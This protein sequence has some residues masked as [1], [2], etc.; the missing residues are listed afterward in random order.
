MTMAAI[1]ARRP[2]RTARLSGARSLP[3]FLL[4]LLT[5]LSCST[6]TV[7]D[8]VRI[9]GQIFGTSYHIQAVSAREIDVPSLST[10][11]SHRLD[12]IDRRMSTYR[13]DSDVSRFNRAETGAW[14]PVDEETAAVVSLAQSVSRETAGCFDI[15]VGP[16]VRLW[17]FGAGA[18]KRFQPPNEQQIAETLTIVGFEKLDVQLAPPAL[19]KSVSGL[20]IDLSAIAKGHAVDAVS[21]LL[22]DHEISGYLVE[23]GGEV[24]AFGVNHDGSAWRI[25]L[26]AA[27]PDARRVD[28]VVSL[29][30]EALATSGD[31]RNF[32]EFEGRTYSHTIDPS[33]A[34]P[35]DHHLAA[36]TVIADS[37]ARADALATAILV[38][39][40]ERGLAWA[41]SQNVKAMLLSRSPN[42]APNG[43]VHRE[44]VNFPEFDVVTPTQAATT[45]SSFLRLMAVAVVVFGIAFLAMSLGTII[46]NRRLKG[47][48]GGLAGM[49]DEHGQT[50]CDMCTKP[51]PE[52]SGD[53][54]ERRSESV[55]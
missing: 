7:A 30:R 29:D 22:E 33:T 54:D 10:A 4:P 11:I 31:Y 51:S 21:R 36:V 20:Q 55:S 18:V 44:T 37:C 6:A 32:F 13:D 42:D 28:A 53:P 27:Q 48:C 25:G 14:F 40:P 50:L 19:R 39:G 24:R 45:A 46:A 9:N 52:C 23:I 43:A 35:V 8:A 26:E 5:L 17:N 1:N 34:S 12:E 49:R 16:A 41:A 15:T 2:V 47:S 3:L 38:M